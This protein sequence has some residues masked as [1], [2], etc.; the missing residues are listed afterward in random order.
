MFERFLSR[1]NWIALAG[2]VLASILVLKGH[3]TEGTAMIAGSFAL[4]RADNTREQ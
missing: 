3:S 1:S 4:L 2:L